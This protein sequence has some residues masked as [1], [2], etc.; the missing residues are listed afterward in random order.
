M[1]NE[2]IGKVTKIKGVTSRKRPHICKWAFLQV[3][4]LISWF[5]STLPLIMQIVKGK[6][7]TGAL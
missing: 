4:S 2:F 6:N 3:L 7:K 5:R 1:C